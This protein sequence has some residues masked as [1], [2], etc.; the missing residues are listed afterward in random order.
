MLQLQNIS[1]T[2]GERILLDDLSATFD[3][4]QKIGL[5]GRNGAGKSTLL[6]IIAG[7]IHPDEG[8]VVIQ[9]YKQIAYLPQEVVMVSPYTVFD[10]AYTVFAFMQDAEKEKAALEQQLSTGESND[11]ESLIER[12]LA[13]DQKLAQFDKHKA[14]QQTA[15]ILNGLGF[16]DI[17]QQDLVMKLST[18]WKMRLVL[19]KLLL[20]Q[21]DF[22]LFDEP[23]NHLDV[24]SKQWFHEF[25][26]NFNG[27]F[28]LVTHDRY[29]LDRT[30]SHIFEVE[31]GKGTMFNGSFT[32]YLEHKQQAQEQKQAAYHQQQREIAQKQK[33]IDRF[34]ASA[35]RA[36]MAQNMVRQLERID[37]I[38]PDPSPPTIKFSLQPAER[39]GETILTIKNVHHAFGDKQLFS[40]INAQISRGQKVALIA[41]N[42]MGKTTLFNLITGK[43]PL[44]GGSVTYGYKVQSALFEQEQARVLKPNNTVLEEA[45]HATNATDSSI[46][47]ALGSFLFPKNDVEKKVSM[48]S[49]GEM[50]RLAMV[51]VFLQRANFLLLDE[52]TNH[53]DMQAK[54][55]LLQALIQYEGTILFVSH[56]Q[57][58]INR[59]ATCIFELTP[60]G[61]DVFDG[62]YDLYLWSKKQ[63]LSPTTQPSHASAPI[64]TNKSE[65][66]ASKEKPIN[67]KQDRTQEKKIAQL[68]KQLAQAAEQFSQ[69]TDYRS[70]QY[71]QL[72]QRI[73]ALTSEL[74]KLKE[75][76]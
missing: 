18:G 64:S 72:L 56:D 46:R 59:L 12:Y 43:Y 3:A 28:L 5:T 45:T 13:L 22:Y 1:L 42:G 67:K 7:L 73:N 23:T 31:H 60:R 19:A 47:A 35:S 11:A 21:A 16:S 40:N 27:G 48:L 14:H 51:K 38:V 62:S 32:Q 50:N 9:R 52:P 65:H 70:T 36:R 15:D 49:G 37:R 2:F 4:H 17:M 6:K 57:D 39:A 10:E 58:F 8:S 25:L 24:T 34:K 29:F 69:I 74:E 55:V 44:Q 63:Q 61:I 66:S 26:K 54:E 68:E 76:C 20:Q 75:E 33:T 53:L 71:Q 30:C 41:A